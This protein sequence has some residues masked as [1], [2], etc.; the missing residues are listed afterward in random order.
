MELTVCE[1]RKDHDRQMARWVKEGKKPLQPEFDDLK[2]ASSWNLYYL[3]LAAKFSVIP[4]L[5]HNHLEWTFYVKE[6]YSTN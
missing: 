1:L 3:H 6:V 4:M 5:Y 2:R